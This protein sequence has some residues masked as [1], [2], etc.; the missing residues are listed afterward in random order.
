MLTDKGSQPGHGEN[1]GGYAQGCCQG[2]DYALVAIT[3][4][5]ENRTLTGCG[6]TAEWPTSP[7]C[8]EPSQF[9]KAVDHSPADDAA[10]IP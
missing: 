6:C 9:Y 3:S 8:V 2:E 4:K 10:D 5:A 7:I 1:L